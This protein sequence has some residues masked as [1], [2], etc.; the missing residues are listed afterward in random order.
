[1]TTCSSHS[2]GNLL[3]QFRREVTIAAAHHWAMCRDRTSTNPRPRSI[4]TTRRVRACRRLP[5]LRLRRQR[6]HRTP[7]RTAGEE[8]DLVRSA[9]AGSLLQQ[10]PNLVIESCISRHG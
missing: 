10:W 5:R 2:E 8:V 7:V 1:M 3:D 4:Q 6:L 9:K